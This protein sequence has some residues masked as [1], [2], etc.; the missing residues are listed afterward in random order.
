MRLRATHGG[1]R[2]CLIQGREPPAVLDCE[3][4]QIDV[5]Q[6][7]WTKNTHA[8]EQRGVNNRDII[9]PED[10]V[11]Y[12]QLPGESLEH[13]CNGHLLLVEPLRHDPDEAVLRQRTRRPTID[14]IFS[15]PLLG[16]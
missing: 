4:Q 10:V 12:S 9:G 13:D 16:T 15:P 11:G 14:P 8:V 7:L 3:R 1:N 6:L 2:N 5:G